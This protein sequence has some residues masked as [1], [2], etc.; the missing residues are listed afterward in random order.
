MMDGTPCA[1]S[2]YGD[3]GG[4]DV[5]AVMTAF[6]AYDSVLF[7]DTIPPS[8]KLQLLAYLRHSDKNFKNARPG[9]ATLMKACSTRRRPTIYENTD[10]LEQE[11][12]IAVRR[13]AGCANHVDINVGRLLTIAETIAAENPTLAKRFSW[14]ATCTVSVPVTSTESATG[15]DRTSTLTGRV[16]RTESATGPEPTSPVSVPCQSGERTGTGTLSGHER[17]NNDSRNAEKEESATAAPASRHD[18]FNLNPQTQHLPIVKGPDG[19]PVLINGCEQDWLEKFPDEGELQDALIEASGGIET[20]DPVR[21]STGITRALTRLSRL[22]REREKDRTARGQPRQTPAAA[23]QTKRSE[24]GAES[25]E[26]FARL[27][28]EAAGGAQ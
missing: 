3:N 6:Q 20:D 5:D 9:A 15:G 22:K 2:V 4:P 28:A 11:K 21:Y 14:A 27:R 12:R 26:L 1:G 8:A 23:R 19:F 16:T 7:D 17:V 10:R 13:R 24:S 25:A 18:P